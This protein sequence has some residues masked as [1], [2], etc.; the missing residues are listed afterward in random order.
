MKMV[1]R[2]I[3]ERQQLPLVDQAWL[4]A[5]TVPSRADTMLAGRTHGEEG[6]ILVVDDD[7]RI[8]A[9]VSQLLSDSRY[10][11]LSARTGAQGLQESRAFS[12]EIHLLLSDFQ[13]PVMSGVELAAAVTRE[14]PETKVLLMSGFAGAMVALHDGWHFL[15]KPFAGSQLR[16]LVAGL[17]SP[18]RKSGFPE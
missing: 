6:T 12:G 10:S 2:P 3:D 5:M 17:I 16:A 7:P 9:A 15:A 18:A 11:V 4:S 13:M 14:R 8:L 1:L